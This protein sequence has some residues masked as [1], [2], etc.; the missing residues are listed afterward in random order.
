MLGVRHVPDPFTE[1]FG[2]F[3][4]L[5]II[6]LGFLVNVYMRHRSARWIW[7]MGALCI[8]VIFV[9]DYAA[10]THAAYDRRLPAGY[11]AEE[12]QQDF[13]SKCSASECLALLFTAPSLALVAYSIGAWFALRTSKRLRA[14][15][16]S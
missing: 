14:A 7:V 4:W 10:I 9:W 5:S 15:V 3:F 2:P 12:F 16:S 1:I 6:A 11:W 13:T 8:A